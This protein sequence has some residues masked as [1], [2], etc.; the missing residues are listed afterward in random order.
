MCCRA[1][2]GYELCLN[3]AQLRDDCCPQC[4]YFTSC[5]DLPDEEK[6]RPKTITT[7]R[8]FTNK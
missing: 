5:M 3:K 6:E 8:R 4:K 2:S 1:C 7:R